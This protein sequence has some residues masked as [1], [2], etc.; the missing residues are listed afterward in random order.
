M[1]FVYQIVARAPGELVPLTFC[2]SEI[3]VRIVLAIS[4]WA[5]GIDKS[6]KDAESAIKDRSVNTIYVL[7]TGSKI[8]FA[9]DIANTIYKRNPQDVFEPVETNY[10]RYTRTV[11]GADSICFEINLR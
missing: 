6:V 7:A 8:D 5:D 11:S 2:E 3:R 9:K 1:D 4:D 10:K